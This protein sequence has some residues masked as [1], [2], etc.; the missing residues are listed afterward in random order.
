MTPP[1]PE[2]QVWGK[3]ARYLASWVRVKVQLV[4][5]E[6]ALLQIGAFLTVLFRGLDYVATPN[7]VA[8]PS[9]LN[10]VENALPLPAWGWCF[11]FSALLGLWGLHFH[12]FPVAA[13]AHGFCVAL[14]SAFAFGAFCELVQG[15]EFYGWRTATGWLFAVL[16]HYLLADASTDAW[17]L[18]HETARKCK[19][20]NL[21]RS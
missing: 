11:C 16:V 13:I 1:H 2:V 10:V 9:T 18:E 15:G 17:K 20:K 14:Y 3:S 21:G 4:F 8:T 19:E 12:R 5:P 6:I 7:S